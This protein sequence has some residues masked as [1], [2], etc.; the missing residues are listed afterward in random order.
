MR[1]TLRTGAWLTVHLSKVN[2]TELG[3]QEW[4]DELFL[5]YGLGH[6]DL[7]T[8]C[9]SYNAK[10][11]ICHHLDCRRGEIVTARHNELRDGVTDLADKYFTSSHVQD[12]PLIF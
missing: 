12:N 5:W 9:D 11:T 7:P 8:Y 1:R 3:A 10:F 4:R 2:G 6:P